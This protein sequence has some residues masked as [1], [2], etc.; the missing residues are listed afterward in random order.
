MKK[1][2]LLGVLSGL[3][4]AACAI[5]FSACN[6]SG[7]PP[8][9]H[10][11]TNYI[12][13]NDATYTSDGT[14]TATCD[15]GCGETDTITDVSTMLESKIEFTTL[16]VDG[17]SVS[18]N[19]RYAT[20]EFDFNNE[21]SVCGTYSYVVADNVYGTNPYL[22]KV[23]PLQEG[24]NT[25]YVTVMNGNNAVKQYTVTL[26]R[27]HMY[28]VSF[29]TQ[30][31]TSIQS[32]TVEEGYLAQEPTA[33]TRTGYTFDGWVYNFA[34]PITGN[35][36]ITANWK[37]NQYT[38][39]IVY[40]NGQANKVITQDYGTE[41]TETLPETLTREYYEFIGWSPAMPTTMPA[42]DKTITAQWQSIFTRN[43][44]TITGLTSYGQSNYTVLNIPSAIDGVAITRIG[45]DAFEYCAGLTSVVIPDGV[46]SIGYS[47]FYCCTSL[48]SVTI[49][50]SVT[51]IGEYAFLDCTS[52]QY[53]IE[54][55]CKY[56]GNSNNPY[57]YLACA[58]STD[59]TSA[60][61]NAQCKFIGS[62]AF[63]SC[64]SLMEIVIPNGVT[65]IGASAFQWCD[66]LKSVTIGGSVTSIGDR[67]FYSCYSLTSVTI[68]GGVTSIGGYVFY[69]CTSLTEIV[70][71]D[72]VTS[73]GFW[74]FYEC[75]S[76]TSITFSDT[77]TWYMTRNSSD[78][79]NKT[80]GMQMSVTNSSDN[81][82]YFTLTY[83][84]YYWYK[85]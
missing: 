27:N 41:I 46:T 1:K 77:S 6:E 53:T 84:N 75:T 17:T 74:A 66:S 50:D 32:Q 24:T 23:A 28:T 12:S 68:G 63:L 57:L 10:S 3:C 79:E 25:F 37:V 9:T 35:T 8:H 48:T 60:T 7:D 38:L 15:N 40:G 61:I 59:I 2:W 18:G 71:P 11:F 16:T 78:W 58:T 51:S 19:V 70:I 33:P 64:D 44:G 5:G 22:M 43:G 14:K 20:T 55:N 76:L 47:A 52:L 26:Y 13:N 31:G 36:T 54:N 80:G 49:P 42:E 62:V 56:L 21:I 45:I 82:Y 34:T 72:S 30:G 65:S 29:A 81:A 4:I 83:Y 73:I 85:L 69:N 67:A 39:T